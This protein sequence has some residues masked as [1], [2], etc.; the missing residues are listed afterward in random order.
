MNPFY[1]IRLS[2]CIGFVIFTCI[3]ASILLYKTKCAKVKSH[4]LKPGLVAVLINFIGSSVA[5]P[6]KFGLPSSVDMLDPT[7]FLCTVAIFMWMVNLSSLYCYFLMQLYYSF[8]DTSF[9][10]KR[11]ILIPHCC[12]MILIAVIWIPGM[13][14]PDYFREIL[15]LAL[16]IW[17]LGTAHLIL[18]L[19]G[20][21]YDVILSQ[22]GSL[23]SMGSVKLTVSIN[24]RQSAMLTIAT[25]LSVIMIID[26]VLLLCYF[27]LEAYFTWGTVEEADSMLYAFHVLIECILLSVFQLSIFMTFSMNAECYKKCCGIC[28]ALTLL[29]H[30]QRVIKRMK[31]QYSTEIATRSPSSTPRNFEDRDGGA[32]SLQTIQKVEEVNI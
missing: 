24:E 16:I 14:A 32:L 1:V 25:R 17:Q 30:R 26:T 9:A 21:L 11:R 28:D 18:L 15:Y 23:Q 27:G 13:M 12:A 29:F 7:N 5:V 19:N 6:L 31:Q 8:Q 4:V 20:I 2:S 10:P 3:L 22:R